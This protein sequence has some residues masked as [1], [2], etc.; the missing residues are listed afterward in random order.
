MWTNWRRRARM[1]EWARRLAIASATTGSLRRSGMTMSP[2]GSRPRQIGSIIGAG[3]A[4][5]SASARQVGAKVLRQFEREL[6]AGRYF[7]RSSTPSEPE[8][9]ILCRSTTPARPAPACMQRDDR[10]GGGRPWRRWRHAASRVLHQR[11][12]AISSRWL[13]GQEP[14]HPAMSAGSSRRRRGRAVLGRRLCRRSSFSFFVER[15]AQR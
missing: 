12:A 15:L 5:G 6:D 2:I 10:T 13:Q 7:K 14:R 8:R 4:V 9:A 1:C 11:G 3:S